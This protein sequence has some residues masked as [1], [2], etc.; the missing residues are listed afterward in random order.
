MKEIWEKM[1]EIWEKMRKNEKKNHFEI[2][3][4]S[5]F[6]LQSIE[7]NEKVIFIWN[8]DSKFNEPQKSVEN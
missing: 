2:W 4:H 8:S 7:L 3:V 1:K 6:G 5:K